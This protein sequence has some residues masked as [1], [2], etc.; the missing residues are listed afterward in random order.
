M[1]ELIDKVCA[2]WVVSERNVFD[3]LPQ[4]GPPEFP[5]AR[6]ETDVMDNQG[7]QLFWH[8]VVGTTVEGGVYY[9][10]AD[11][12]DEPRLLELLEALNQGLRKAK[13]LA[14][15][16]KTGQKYIPVWIHEERQDQYKNP[17]Q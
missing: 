3:S 11:D 10:P 17:G 2:E 13:K 9:L 8:A 16:P 4:C 5:E 14:T 15:N 12:C 6:L 7:F 1:Q